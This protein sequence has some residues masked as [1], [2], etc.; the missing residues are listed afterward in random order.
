M[1]KIFALTLTLLLSLCLAACVDGNEDDTSSPTNATTFE[2]TQETTTVPD[3]TSTT[4]EA[5]RTPIALPEDY[6]ELLVLQ[7]IEYYNEDSKTIERLYRESFQN[8]DDYG[9]AILPDGNVVEGPFGLGLFANTDL[10]IAVQSGSAV[11]AS[12]ATHPPLFDLK[13]ENGRYY[14]VSEPNNWKCELQYT[15]DEIVLF[16][17]YTRLPKYHYCQW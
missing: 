12:G 17:Q 6:H 14:L 13:H 9:R 8:T 7:Y 4:Q 2:H 10:E 5:N 3:T 1:R 16:D 11:L 15:G